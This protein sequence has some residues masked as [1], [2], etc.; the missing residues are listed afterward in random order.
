MLCS[1]LV[2]CLFYI[3][4]SELGAR[5][6][7]VTGRLEL[8]HWPVMPLYPVW[9][10]GSDILWY[11]STPS[12]LQFRGLIVFLFIWIRWE[13]VVVF[14][15]LHLVEHDQ[16]LSVIELSLLAWP[17]L[18]LVEAVD[19]WVYLS[20]QTY[21][22]YWIFVSNNIMCTDSAT[23]CR[24]PR[25]HVKRK[26]FSLLSPSSKCHWKANLWCDGL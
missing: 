22:I 26:Y 23:M 24:E 3:S 21:W 2:I 19:D 25:G 16:T 15:S 5:E 9:I 10:V 20:K 11:Y 12:K 17:L 13:W 14:Q 6:R 7:F 4:W 18:T 1:F 8:N